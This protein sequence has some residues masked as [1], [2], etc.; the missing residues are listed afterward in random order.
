MVDTTS[1]AEQL[2]ERLKNEPIVFI[3]ASLDEYWSVLDELGEEPFPLEYDIEYINGQIRAQIGM[4]SDRHETIVLNIGGILRTAFYDT[5]NIR[6]MGSNKLVYV[7]VC[8]L[9]VKPDVLVMNA[10]SQLF[11]RKGQESGIIN[12]YMV[13]EVHSDSTYHEDMH[14]KL[15][16]YKQLES[17]QYIIYI[18]QGVPFV[19]IYTKQQDSRHWLNEDYDQLDMVVQLD[20]IELPMKDIYHKVALTSARNA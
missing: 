3:D 8:E 16:C 2:K 6:V 5:P 14:V 18:E 15:R 12:P 19:S 10:A 17:V 1:L 4:A 7:P 9:A 20:G 11:P 13:V